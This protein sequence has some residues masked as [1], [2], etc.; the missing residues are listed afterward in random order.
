MAFK[1]WNI[2]NVSKEKAKILADECGISSFVAEILVARGYDTPVLAYDFLSDDHELE[3]PFVMADMQKAAERIQKAVDAS[4]KIVIYGDYDCDGVTSTVALYT[5]LE[6]V[7]A[8]VSYHIPEREEGY[9]LNASSLEK[10]AGQGTVL[11]ITV[12]NGIS[13]FKECERAYEL[14][15]QVVITDHHQ[16]GESLPMA[17]AVVNP[18][19]T[20]CGSSFKDLCGV[21]VVLKLIAALEGGDYTSALDCFSDIAAIGTI[22][23]V[24]PLV[25]ENRIIVKHGISMLEMT[26]NAGIIAMLEVAKLSGKQLTSEM[27]AFGIVPRINAAG[28]LSSAKM[29]V[30][31]LLSEDYDEAYSLAQKIDEL[32]KSRQKME[33]DILGEIDEFLT[34]ENTRLYDRVMVLSGE[35]WHHGVIGIVSAKVLERYSKPN[36]LL[37]VDGDEARGSARSVEG[38]SLY[39][40]LVASSEYL[41]RFGGHKQAAGM[42]IQTDDIKAFADSINQYAGENFD[43][44]PQYTYQVDKVIK[45]EEITV[46]TIED[47]NILQ[48]F[49]TQNQSP[50]FMLKNFRIDSIYPLTENKHIRLKLISGKSVLYALYFGMSTERFPYKLGDTVDMVA[51][52]DINTYNGKESV[53]IKI[54]DMRPTGFMESKFFAA[55]N[56]YEKIKR[57]EPIDKKLKDRVIPTRDEVGIVYKFLAEN[58]GYAGDID[59]TYIQLYKSGLNYCKIRVAID[60]LEEIG[61]LIV[62]PLKDKVEVIKNP[63][64]KD[65]QSSV[66]LQQLQR[67]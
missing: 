50:L 22:G 26:E 42:S 49:G 40:A 34:K 58:K 47:M 36:I 6:S 41:T 35:N 9:G 44:M 52:L 1:K 30:E 63:E 43:E 24:V 20:D 60:I 39:H 13:A 66:L 48:P 54:K 56:I 38:F 19:R 45:A 55:K 64:K 15:M 31:M 32:N 59:G 8:D 3:D 46:E 65:L 11:I 21:G 62:S 10:L 51:S 17:E 7:G 29:A 25:G 23:D 2:S 67:V 14:G 4:E 33:Q 57:G 27:I 37:S 28:R 16:T 12:D 53:S 18:H 61:L 5:Y